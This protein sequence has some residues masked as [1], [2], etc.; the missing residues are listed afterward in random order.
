MQ[1]EWLKRT[2]G[3]SS[4]DASKI[5]SEAMAKEKIPGI[6]Y[7]DQGSR[8]GGKGTSNFVVFPGGEKMLNILERQ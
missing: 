4:D 6:K 8:V 3:M 7:L 5:I 2:K 1:K